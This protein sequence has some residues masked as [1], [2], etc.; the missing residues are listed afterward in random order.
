V[1]GYT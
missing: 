1:L